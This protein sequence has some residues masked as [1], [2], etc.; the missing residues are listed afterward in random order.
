MEWN[1][2]FLSALNQHNRRWI[3]DGTVSFVC[4]VKYI[5][6]CTR[7]IVTRTMFVDFMS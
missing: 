4:A 3:N 1:H 6:V 2:V 5:H 7:P